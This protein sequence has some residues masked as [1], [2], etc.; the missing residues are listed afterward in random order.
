MLARTPLAAAVAATKPW[1]IRT[2]APSRSMRQS[3][4]RV[5]NARRAPD[6]LLVRRTDRHCDLAR[7]PSLSSW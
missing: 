6:R 4:S 1:S 2:L 3:A 7:E 5:R